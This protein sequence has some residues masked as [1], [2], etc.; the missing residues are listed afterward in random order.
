MKVLALLSASLIALLINHATAQ[1]HAPPLISPPGDEKATKTKVLETGA[2]LLQS[3]NPVDGFD[4][5]LVG[6]HAMKDHPELQMDAHHYCHQVKEDFMQC[7]LFDGNSGKAN[8]H[9]VEYI[10][11]ERLFEALA[12]EEKKLWHPHN[13]EILSGQL[14]APGLPKVAEKALMKSKMNSYGKTWHLWNTGYIN[15]FNDALPVGQPMLAWSLNRDGELLPGLMQERERKL[16]VDLAATRKERA[17]L[18]KL[19]KPQSGVD[20]LKGKFARPTQ[21]IPGVVNK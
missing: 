14:I 18:Q 8:L 19:A 6:F 17:E 1:K 9:G 20:E 15:Q 3:N 16:N 4:I 2:Q 5:Y 7:I 10:I 13:G 12:P 21:D 11:S